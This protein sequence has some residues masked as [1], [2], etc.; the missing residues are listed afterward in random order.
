MFLCSFNKGVS[1]LS[2]ALTAQMLYAIQCRHT[3]VELHTSSALRIRR[4]S[5]A[6]SVH[7]TPRCRAPRSR[8]RREDHRK[9]VTKQTVDTELSG[10]KERGRAS[11]QR[12]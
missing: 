7:R 4:S 5:S 10:V 6:A 3:F 11:R 1:A 8:R 12:E 2:D 9:R